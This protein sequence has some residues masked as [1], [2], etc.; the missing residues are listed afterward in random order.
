MKEDSNLVRK[1]L[2]YE[3]E[4][5]KTR[6]GIEKEIFEKGISQ[7]I[8]QGI[9]KKQREMVISF[10]NQGVSLDIISKASNLTISEV[11]EILKSK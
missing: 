7:G 5:E 10:Y 8:S 3:L 9:E 2:D 4:E 6:R 11:E 1:Y